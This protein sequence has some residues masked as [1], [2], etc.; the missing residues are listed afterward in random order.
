[1][2]AI[3]LADVFGTERCTST[4]SRFA[5]SP[6]RERGMNLKQME[7]NKSRKERNHSYRSC[8][9]RN[10]ARGEEVVALFSKLPR[11]TFLVAKED[12]LLATIKRNQT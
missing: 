12:T 8:N 2:S 6:V 9:Q 5:I 4:R 3:N 10:E 1:M 7:V 11:E